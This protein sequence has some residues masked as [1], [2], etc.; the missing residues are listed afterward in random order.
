MI[1]AGI[2][3]AGYGPLL[4][5][6]V[7]GCCAMSVGDDA[8]VDGDSW[9]DLWRSLRRIA[10][11]T[12]KAR[13]LHINDSK[14]VYSPSAGL[15]GLE[16]SMLCL[17]SCRFGAIGCLN[18]L[19]RHVSPETLHHIADH[20]WYIPAADEKFPIELEAPAVGIMTNALKVEL[21]QARCRVEHLAANVML[22]GRYNAMVGQ[23]RNKGSV[24]FS[25]SAGHIDTLLR[26][27]ANK[28]LII[29]CDRQGGREHY[30]RLLQLMFEDW[31]LEILKEQEDCSDY[32]LVHPDG[33]SARIL[34]ATK[35]ESTS[36]PT[37][38]A[39]MLCK[40]LREAMMH[41]F[42]AFWRMHLPDLVPTAGYYTDGLRFMK[43]I[44]AKRTA[45][46]IDE[47]RLVRSR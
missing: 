38:V 9:P 33:R 12:R 26:Q 44:D 11:R 30:G 17:L 34:F 23:T 19:L 18:D 43:D 14:L 13:K 29:V 41:R 37:A 45:M 16:H 39:S 31:Q 3:E 20:P 35:S 47:A 1:L 28:G 25:L 40:Y 27:F 8:P 42:N 7:V 32:R 46:G 15:K 21:Q 2:D 36:M 4:G 10:S 6:L 24:L 5:P 22:E